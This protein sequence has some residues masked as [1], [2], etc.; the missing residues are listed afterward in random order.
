LRERLINLAAAVTTE[1]E[2]IYD[3]SYLPQMKTAVLPT[4]LT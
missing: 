1:V 2:A 3:W 4:K